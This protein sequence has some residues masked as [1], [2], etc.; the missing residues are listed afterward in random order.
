MKGVLGASPGEPGLV[1]GS[2]TL[3]NSTIE[4]GEQCVITS[5]NASWCGDRW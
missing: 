2:I 3:W 1:S 5:G 4:P